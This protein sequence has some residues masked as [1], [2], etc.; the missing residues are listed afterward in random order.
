MAG[1][2]HIIG[3][4]KFIRRFKTQGE[5]WGISFTIN[6]GHKGDKNGFYSLKGSAFGEKADALSKLQ[7]NDLVS[8]Q[9]FLKDDSYKDKTGQWK[10]QIG[11]VINDCDILTAKP[12]EPEEGMFPA[13]DNIE[14]TSYQAPTME[15]P[16]MV[17]P[18]EN[19][20]G[21][22]QDDDLPF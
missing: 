21:G 19:K 18:N 9:G 8:I 13:D 14:P 1:Y 11:V 6:C 15:I 2:I 4:V 12:N 20:L 10:N 7:D 5:K 16:D 22:I 3:N 17:E